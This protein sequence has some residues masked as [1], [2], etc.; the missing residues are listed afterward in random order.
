MFK[1]TDARLLLIVTQLDK[2][3][4]TT[5]QHWW[6]IVMRVYQSARLT[7]AELMIW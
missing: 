1:V 2:D 3:L 7:N 4:S 5:S 6:T